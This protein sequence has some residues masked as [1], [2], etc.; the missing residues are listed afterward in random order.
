[1]HDAI[2]RKKILNVH[3]LRFRCVTSLYHGDIMPG[4]MDKEC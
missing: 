2:L 1:M 3:L 4:F